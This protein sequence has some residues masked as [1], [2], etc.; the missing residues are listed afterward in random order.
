MFPLVLLVPLYFDAAFFFRSS[1]R[2][3]AQPL[4]LLPFVGDDTF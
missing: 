4:I 1:Q 3:R 2:I